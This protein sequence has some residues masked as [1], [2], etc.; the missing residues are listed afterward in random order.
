MFEPK[1]IITP[2]I[3]AN[4]KKIATIINELNHLHF[5]D[6]ILMEFEKKANSLSAYA[7]TSIEGNPLPL[8]EVKKILKSHPKNARDSEREVINY[9]DALRKLNKKI[10]SKSININLDLILEIHKD[11]MMDL[12][13][14]FR[15][16]KLRCEP[17][18]VN[19]PKTGQSAYLPPDH[20]DVSM[21]M[22]EL[23]SFLNK[24]KN[25]L[26]P[27]ILAAIFHKQFV[28]I[29]PFIDGNGRTSRLC[30]KIILA[31]MGLNTFNLF[32]FENY[33]NKNVTKYFQ[34]V[35]IHG[36]YYEIVN[37]VDYTEWIEYF[38][39][40]IIDE[41]LRVEKELKLANITPEEKLKAHDVQLMGYIEKHGFITDSE[42][43]KI[44]SRAKATRSLDFRRLL[45]LGRIERFGKGKNTYYKLKKV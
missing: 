3:L 4:I 14:K 28:I 40:G 43:S 23:V 15:C 31:S 8:T 13:E 19:D 5:P 41:L 11:I 36:N 18:F 6:V 26:D 20:N 35:G 1:H 16:G 22:S 37:T 21:L 30:T 12:I 29:H 39:G 7:S 17:V 27:L 32:S 44:V 2:D 45:D 42:Y 24:N 33:Y 10:K 25:S 38:T 9:N 34:K